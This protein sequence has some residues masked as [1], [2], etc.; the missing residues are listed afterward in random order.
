M[1]STP[2][3]TTDASTT[4]DAASSC[5]TANTAHIRIGHVKSALVRERA[6]RKKLGDLFTKRMI[7]I[8]DKLTA[9]SSGLSDARDTTLADTTLADLIARVRELEEKV[10]CVFVD[11]PHMGLRLDDVDTRF[12]A[13]ERSIREMTRS[14]IR[15]GLRIDAI[16]RDNELR[17]ERT[18]CCVHCTAETVAECEG[19]GDKKVVTGESGGDATELVV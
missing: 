19:E 16:E 14:H 15:D 2:A 8:D 5:Y 17:D 3:T 18:S 12:I 6:A 10:D 4:A 11:I 13:L 7:E 9:V 1:S